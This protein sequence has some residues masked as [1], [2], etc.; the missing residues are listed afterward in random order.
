MERTS[1]R[2]KSSRALQKPRQGRVKRQL[3]VQE[4][5]V[6]LKVLRVVAMAHQMTIILTIG[7]LLHV[8][9]EALT[10]CLQMPMPKITMLGKI[11]MLQCLEN[12]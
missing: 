5:M 6:P 1:L 2:L 11:Y 4:M 10:R 8:R 9:G 7:N 3:L 12:L